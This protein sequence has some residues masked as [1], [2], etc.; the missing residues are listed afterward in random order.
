[1]IVTTSNVLPLLLS[2]FSPTNK[3]CNFC[4]GS[5]NYFLLLVS[6]YCCSV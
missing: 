3:P 6:G 1:M 2:I 5:A 4:G